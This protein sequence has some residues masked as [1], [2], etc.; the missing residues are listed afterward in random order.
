M[1]ELP[2]ASEESLSRGLD[3]IKICATLENVDVAKSEEDVELKC[4]EVP[5]FIA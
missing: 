5:R 1:P 4:V 3:K 2:E